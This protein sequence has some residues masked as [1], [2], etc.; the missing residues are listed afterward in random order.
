MLKK[1]I[2]NFF[3]AASP[4]VKKQIYN[5]SL[6]Y[7]CGNTHVSFS[8][9]GPNHK[10]M[11]NSLLIIKSFQC[12]SVRCVDKAEMYTRGAIRVT[13]NFTLN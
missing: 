6:E 9:M 2:L 4:K 3:S 10:V 12:L 1:T 13:H 8:L 11:D 5:N 7:D